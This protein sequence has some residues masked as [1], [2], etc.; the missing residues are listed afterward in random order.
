MAQVLERIDVERD[1][2]RRRKNDKGSRKDKYEHDAEPE[3]GD[4]DSEHDET[5]GETFDPPAAGCRSNAE[6]HADDNRDQHRESGQLECHRQA[7]CQQVGEGGVT[8]DVRSEVAMKKSTDPV[9]VLS[10]QTLVET[11]LVP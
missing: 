9:H 7:L 5:F 6:W 8:D 3:V 1:V 4:A 11:E 10:Q 2:T